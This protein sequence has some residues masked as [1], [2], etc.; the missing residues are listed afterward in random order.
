MVKLETQIV[1]ICNTHSYQREIYD[2]L[3]IKLT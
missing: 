3:E 1:Y 2:V